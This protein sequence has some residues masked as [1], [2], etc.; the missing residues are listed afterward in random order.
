MKKALA[1]ILA[2]LM[3]LSLAACGGNGTDGSQDTTTTTAENK[4]EGESKS[5][6]GNTPAEGGSIEVAVTY[7]GD[8]LAVFKTLTDKFTAETGITV[9][10]D[11][12]GSD[13][14]ATMK[15]RMASNT[16]PDVFQTHGWSILRYKEYLMPLNDQPWYSDLDESGLGVIADAD[17]TIYVLMIS[18]L[19]NAT[20]V[21]TD[22]TDEA[23]SDIYS[24]HTWDD[25]YEACE[26]VKAIGKT[27]IGSNSGSGIFANIAGSFV[28]YPGEAAVDEKAQ[29]DGTWD[30]QSYKSTLMDWIAKTIDAGFW[31]EDVLT[32]SNDDMTQ[33]FAD[34]EAAFM[35]GNDP[36]FCISCLTLNPDANFALLPNFASKEGGTEEVNIGEGDTFGIWKDT[37]NVE[38]AKAFL[39]FMAQ[40]ENAKTMNDSTGKI[41]SLKSAMAIDEGY[42]LQMLKTFQEK[43]ADREIFYDNLWDRKYMPSGMWGIFGNACNDFFQDHSPENTDAVL[44][45]LKENYTDLY[46]E[47]HSN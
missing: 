10:I 31:A 29:L 28:T 42:G 7:T 47:A 2:A 6:E 20:L 34:G 18:E 46:E 37:K 4:T 14:E 17:G 45:Y 16:L 39:N 35:L 9:V 27:P 36:G 24:I 11:E 43:C 40:A 8:Q 1:L 30:W 44:D 41:A 12:Y 25:L 23:G 3:V 38:Q 26:K 5:E 19:V 33:K 15:S 32:R 21:N 13:Y 22:V